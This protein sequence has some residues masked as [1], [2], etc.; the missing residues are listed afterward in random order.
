MCFTAVKTRLPGALSNDK[1]ET[2]E[3]YLKN[4]SHIF[5]KKKFLH[6]G[7]DDDQE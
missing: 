5:P 2:K 3:T 1:C 7:M 6:L 4:I